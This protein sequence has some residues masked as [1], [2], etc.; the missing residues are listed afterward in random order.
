M[1]FLRSRSYTHTYD[2]GRRWRLCSRAFGRRERMLAEQV[3]LRDSSN[4]SAIAVYGHSARFTGNV[5]RKVD[6]T[7]PAVSYRPAAH[8]RPINPKI[9]SWPKI[10]S[11][12]LPPPRD[13]ALPSAP[14]PCPIR[15]SPF[16]FSLP[17]AVDRW[18]PSAPGGEPFRE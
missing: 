2:R 1:P 11:P 3:N 14:P 10:P 17:D 16:L 9:L 15:L 12:S 7:K 5:R 13:L 4:Q 18:R 6:Y 8:K